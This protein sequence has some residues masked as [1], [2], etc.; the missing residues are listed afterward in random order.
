MDFAQ[1]IQRVIDVAEEANAEGG[2]ASEE[3]LAR[4]LKNL[5]EENVL[6]LQTFMYFGAADQDDIHELHEHLTGMTKGQ[7]DAVDTMV[8]KRLNLPS[9]LRKALDKSKN[10]GIDIEA[11]F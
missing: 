5:S 4:Y 3:D 10:L 6:K 7:S 1:I 8:A 11:S 9:N 2:R